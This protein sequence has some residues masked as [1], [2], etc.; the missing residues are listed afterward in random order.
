MPCVMNAANEVAVAKFLRDEIKFL[1]IA[2]IVEKTMDVASTGE[3][4]G[5]Q[6]VENL[7]Q[8]KAIDK[9]S[10]DIANALWLPK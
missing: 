5:L 10:R 1:D 7:E 8:L 9:E 4:I 2:E 6:K 3:K